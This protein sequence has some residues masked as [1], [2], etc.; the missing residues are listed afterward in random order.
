MH[1]FQNEFLPS[2]ALRPFVD[3]YWFQS[4]TGELCEESPVQR[5]VPLGMTEL[6]VH[7][8]GNTCYVFVDNEWKALPDAYMVGVYKDAVMWKTQ[9]TSYL[10]GIRLKPESL[11]RLFKVPAAGVFNNYTDLDTFFGKK[12]DLADRMMGI[13]EVGLLIKIAEDFLYKQLCH[14]NS[15]RNYVYEATNLIRKSKGDIRLE[16]LS[17]Q[18]YVSERQLQ[19]GFKDCLGASPKT[20]IRI[21][22]FRNAYEY[23]QQSGNDLSWANVSYNF[24]YADQ[25]HFIKDFKQFTGAVPT[26]I[27]QKAEE[28][29][30]M[31]RELAI[32]N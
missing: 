8:K 19:R 26:A 2:A 17:G 29:P 4:F 30:Q 10:F 28:F 32:L 15:E 18:L 9:G 5:C 23:V 3:C 12:T 24:G 11:I 27:F 14:L 25:A 13:T 31:S 6:I 20:Y 21:I 7:V 16:E 22:R 1:I